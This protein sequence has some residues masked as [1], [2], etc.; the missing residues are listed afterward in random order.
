ML[1]RDGGLRDAA[2]VADGQAIRRHRRTSPEDHRVLNLGLPTVPALCLLPR[3]RTLRCSPAPPPR[4]GCATYASQSGILHQPTPQIMTSFYFSYIH[5]VL[6]LLACGGGIPAL[7]PAAPG[8]PR[9][10]PGSR[11]LACS[12]KLSLLILAAL[13]ASQIPDGPHAWSAN[14][15][16]PRPGSGCGK[17]M[18]AVVWAELTLNLDTSRGA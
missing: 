9:R 7:A 10:W 1:P 11:G 4:S 18:S 13:A 15:R 5:R 17:L 14:R 3:E 2:D 6:W 16:T 8:R 12:G